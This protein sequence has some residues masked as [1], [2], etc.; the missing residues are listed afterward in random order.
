M[1]LLYVASICGDY[2]VLSFQESELSKKSHK[3]IYDFVESE[4]DG[5]YFD[6]ENDFKIKT[7]EFKGVITIGKFEVFLN[8]LN[9][10]YVTKKTDWL[11]VDYSN[12]E[13]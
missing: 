7:Y 13:N 6:K 11:I 4:H 5:C 10:Y 2:G 8:D 3:E 9:D 12:E 1:K